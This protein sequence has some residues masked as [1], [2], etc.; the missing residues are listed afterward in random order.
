VACVRGLGVS[1]GWWWSVAWVC[2]V[3]L[4]ATRDWGDE[5][6]AAASASHFIKG[7][8]QTGRAKTFVVFSFT[9]IES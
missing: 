3:D 7:G 4:G 8:L 5:R 1:A 2:A 6:R 9:P